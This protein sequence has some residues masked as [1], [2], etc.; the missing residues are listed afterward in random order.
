MSERDGTW[1]ARIIATF[2]EAHVRAIVESA[3]FGDDFLANELTRILMGR[4]ERILRRYLARLSSLTEPVVSAALLPQLC[5]RDLSVAAGLVRPAARHYSAGVWRDDEFV[6]FARAKGSPGQACVH[7]PTPGIPS[8]DPAYLIA[9]APP[10]L[11]VDVVAQ[12]RGRAPEKPARVHLYREGDNYR[13]VGLERPD[14][15]DAPD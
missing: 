11:I 13:V 14:D 4:R 8:A 10:Y 2:S 1:M 6:G 5:L 9:V 12:T 3:Q 7:L 15:F